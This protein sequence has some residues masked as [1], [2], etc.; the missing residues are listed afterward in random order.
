MTLQKS[1][2]KKE[3][4]VIDNL[5]GHLVSSSFFFGHEWKLIIGGE[6]RAGFLPRSLVYIMTVFLFVCLHFP[7]GRFFGGCLQQQ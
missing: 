6:K 5:D 3:A 2:L 4:T 1:Q 7:F